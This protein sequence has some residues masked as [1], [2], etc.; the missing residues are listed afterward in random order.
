M[1]TAVKLAE[2][3]LIPD[4]LTRVGIRRLLGKRLINESVNNSLK[5]MTDAMSRGP[6]AIQTNAAND[7]HYEVPVEFFLAMLG[8]RLKYSC[9]YFENGAAD[10]N[11]AE[12]HMLSLTVARA[13]LSDSQKILELGCGW[14]SLSL[15][16]AKQYPMSDITAVSNS[17]LQREFIEARACELGLRNLK[18]V[19][20]D[21]NDFTT[22]ETFDRVVSIEMF[23]HLRN[24]K[25]LFKRISSWLRPNGRLF[26]HVFCH[27]DTPYF[28]SDNSD[29]D[30][31]ARN[32]FTG[33]VMPSFDLPAAF[34]EDLK[35]V[36]RWQVNGMNYAKTCDAWLQNLD[37]QKAHIT[38]V[39]KKGESH[40]H[41]HIQLNRWRM[42]VMACRELFAFNEGKEWFVGHYLLEPVS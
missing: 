24:Y 2:Q 39:F 22:T 17:Q 6:L 25:L 4:F 40:E 12:E 15:F 18:V 28:F 31:M 1:N 30:W 21:I 35:I 14:G 13:G 33:G 5:A 10:L 8:D 41:A 37:T 16:M 34:S 29:D 19:T 7:Q 32:F 3:G 9:S 42:F 20:C 26:F 27:K 38:D 23:E 11:T 36:S